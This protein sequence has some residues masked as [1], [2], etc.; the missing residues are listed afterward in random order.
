MICDFK[1]DSG[2]LE[3]AGEADDATGTASV[4]LLSDLLQIDLRATAGSYLLRITL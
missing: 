2:Y 3:D 4:H 1:R